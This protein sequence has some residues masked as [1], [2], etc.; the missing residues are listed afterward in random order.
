MRARTRHMPADGTDVESKY[1]ENPKK[2]FT[3]AYVYL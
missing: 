2:L 3:F 1:L